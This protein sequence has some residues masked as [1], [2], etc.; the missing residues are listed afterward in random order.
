MALEVVHG[1]PHLWIAGSE[2]LNEAAGNGG[3]RQMIDRILRRAVGQ[4]R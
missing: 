2:A 4:D 1:L 3:T